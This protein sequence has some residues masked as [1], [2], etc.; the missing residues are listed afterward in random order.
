MVSLLATS[1]E[2]EKS[3]LIQDGASSV[4]SIAF[5]KRSILLTST[6]D[7]VQKSIEGGSIERTLRA[8]SNQIWSLV[9][10]DDNRLISV[11]YDDMI[12]V[13]SLDSGSILKRI[14]L[15]SPNTLVQSLSIQNDVVF[16]GGNDGM[17]RQLDLLTGEI[18]FKIGETC[19]SEFLTV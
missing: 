8:H 12:I 9:V 5:Y 7:I 14:W 10:T 17:V 2:H 15:G 16:A 3:F 1:L 4:I 11:A 13:W 18:V 19:E 6:N